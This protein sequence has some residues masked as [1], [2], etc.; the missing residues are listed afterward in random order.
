MGGAVAGVLL[1]LE[2]LALASGQLLSLGPLA[3]PDSL[4]ERAP[5][6]Y[7]ARFETSKG[8]FVIEVRREWA[9]IGAD[10]FYNLVKHGFYDDCRFFRV[11]DGR[12][13]EIT[14]RDVAGIAEAEAQGVK[15]VLGA[16]ST[17]SVSPQTAEQVTVRFVVPL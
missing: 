16:D 15:R 6:T 3:K 5:E 1:S 11:I 13:L 8:A 10:R 17:Y 7:K 4:T 9:P 2:L 12:A 14:F